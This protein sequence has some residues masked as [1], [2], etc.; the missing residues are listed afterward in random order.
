[1]FRT[2]FNHQA[3]RVAW[4][5]VLASY[6]ALKHAT[7]A[8]RRVLISQNLTRAEA[9]E[10]PRTNSN[11]ETTVPFAAKPNSPHAAFGWCDH[12]R[13]AHRLAQGN[14]HDHALDLQQE[15]ADLKR[16]DYLSNSEASVAG[17]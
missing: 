5:R 10:R 15:L 3:G 13:V 1:M 7:I 4:N 8:G 16:V 14:A 6:H 9:L 11:R 17:L 12:C 2:N